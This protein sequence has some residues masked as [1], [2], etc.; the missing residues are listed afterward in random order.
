L[1][2]LTS[3]YLSAT[4]EGGTKTSGYLSL[5]HSPTSSLVP[6]FFKLLTSKCSENTSAS[7]L[8]RSSVSYTLLPFVRSQRPWGEVGAWVGER[9]ERGRKGAEEDE[10]AGAWTEKSQP[11]KGRGLEVGVVRK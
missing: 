3:L 8:R 10:G 9:M 2:D 4:A 5:T 11:A 1:S 7:Q 6:T